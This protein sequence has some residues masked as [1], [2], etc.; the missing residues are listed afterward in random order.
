MNEELKLDNQLCFS[1][2][3]T[4][5]NMTRL[6]QPILDKF[7]LTYPQYIILLALFESE[8]LDFKELSEIIDLKKATLSPILS[9]IEKLGYVYRDINP[10][11]ARRF[12]VVLSEKG[13]KLRED[14]VEVPC[15]LRDQ[16]N[17]TAS[18]YLLLMNE[19]NELLDIMKEGKN[20]E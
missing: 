10:L 11:D 16:L 18:K 14:I 7:N 19:L 15:K 8:T 12:N 5:R 1:L 2:Y 4:S 17:L 9:K 6:Y 20:N 3:R 13:K